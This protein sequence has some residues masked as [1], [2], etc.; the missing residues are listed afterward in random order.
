MVKRGDKSRDKK[1]LTPGGYRSPRMVHLVKPGEIVQGRGG[2][3]RVTTDLVL[4]PGGFR[5]RSLVHLI[6]PNHELIVEHDKFRIQN[7]HDLRETEVA[8]VPWG[9]DVPALDS[10]WI[11]Y[12][13]W[14]NGS[15]EPFATFTSAWTVPPAPRVQANPLQTIF[16][17]NGIQ[18]YG[19]NYGILQP[20]L[21]WG[22]SKVGG[23]P[24]W[25]IASW[26]VTSGGPAFHSPLARVTPGE[27]LVGVMTRT[28]KH[29]GEFSYLCEFQNVAS[30]R[31]PV[32]KIS[33]LVWFNET[34]EA[35][36]IERCSNYPNTTHTTLAQI[37][38]NKD[39]GPL[40]PNWTSAN[41]VADCGQHATAPNPSEVN[42][43]YRAERGSA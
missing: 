26:Y 32:Q 20:I 28:A 31:L 11:T 13:Y 35:Y 10:G 38:I 21:Q 7:M 1:V 42:I 36:Q 18:N 25:S 24:Y 8:M 37:H 27:R 41:R 17:F 34:L 39:G 29:G 5:S 30:T 15:G 2:E 22:P 23:G 33:E 43:F 12:C 4:T 19:R 9:G 40:R 14:N 6:E 16:L 3:T